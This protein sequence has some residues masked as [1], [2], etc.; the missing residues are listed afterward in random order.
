MDLSAYL[1]ARARAVDAALDAALP[2]ERTPPATLHRAMRYSVFA[3]GKR[4]RPV[5]ALAAAEAVTGGDAE[6]ASAA[7][8][9][10]VALEMIHTYS[11]IHDDL[12]AMDDD[13][14]RRGRP[15]NHKVFGEAAAILAGD[16]LLTE[17]FRVL[18]E[19]AA[20]P[21]VAPDVHAARLLA[22]AAEIARG[23]GPAGMVG[24]QMADL[25]GEGR[26]VT[27]EEVEFIHLR[28]TAALIVAS[29]VGGGLAVGATPVQVAALRRYG[30]AVGLAFQIADDVLD[31][32]GESAAMGKGTGGDAAAGKATYPA[33]AGLEASKARAAR[34]ADEAIDALAPFGEAGRP[35][36]AI[37]RFVV[38][39]RS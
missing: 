21:G 25:E 20:P 23:A 31:V 15:T 17:A 32:E 18:T 4:I 33:V 24:G 16:G 29:V 36:A 13:D 27:L 35:L 3:G 19:A 1:E 8:P 2:A 11:L 10:A 22:A 7:M 34:L 30:T 9:V 37:A 39:R 26:A 6:R 12:P 5:L 28:K 14:L 38:D